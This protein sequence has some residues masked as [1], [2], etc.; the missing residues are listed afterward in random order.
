MATRYSAAE[1]LERILM[2]QTQISQL[3]KKN[4]L[5]TKKVRMRNS[6]GFN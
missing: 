2:E 6:F 3:T 5:Q 1:A 4:F